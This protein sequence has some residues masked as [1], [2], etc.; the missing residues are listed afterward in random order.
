[1]TALTQ[2]RPATIRCQTCGIDVT[3][4]LRGG[5]VPRFCGDRCRKDSYAGECVD[6]G[7]K[8]SGSDGRG[9][10]RPERCVK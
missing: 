9:P 8:L 6:C 7:A 3:V 10:N 2:G 4:A 5:R 1:M